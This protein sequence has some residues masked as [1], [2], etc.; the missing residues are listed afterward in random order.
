MLAHSL[1]I[2]EYFADDRLSIDYQFQYSQSSG[3]PHDLCS[4]P[5]TISNLVTRVSVPAS[6]ISPC[7]DKRDRSIDDAM[8][9]LNCTGLLPYIKKK[10]KKKKKKF[11]SL[12][13]AVHYASVIM[14]MP[15]IPTC[16]DCP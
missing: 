7:L 3:D 11:I 10:K 14:P 9:H 16:T 13:A 15:V 4:F 1:P 12:R 2:Q 5:S 6:N 8:P